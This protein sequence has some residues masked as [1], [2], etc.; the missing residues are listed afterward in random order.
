MIFDLTEFL[1]Y[2]RIKTIRSIDDVINNPGLL[3]GE[4]LHGGSAAIV[5]NPLQNQA[6]NVDAEPKK[7]NKHT[8]KC[9]ITLTDTIVL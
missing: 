6:H 3:F 4:L 1:R 8:H 7:N 9:P 5:L 2:S